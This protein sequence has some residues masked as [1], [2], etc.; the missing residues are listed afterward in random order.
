MPIA[1]FAW[2]TRV[3]GVKTTNTNAKAEAFKMAG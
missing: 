3:R 1:A 2:M